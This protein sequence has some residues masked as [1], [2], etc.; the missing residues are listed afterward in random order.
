MAEQSTFENELPKKSTVEYVRGL[1]ANGN[2]ILINKSDLASV[3]GGLM[4][5]SIVNKTYTNT[6]S[7][8]TVT[9]K[10]SGLTVGILMANTSNNTKPVVLFY[11]AK[12]AG[13]TYNNSI[14]NTENPDVKIGYKSGENYIYVECTGGGVAARTFNIIIHE[15]YDVSKDID[16]QQ[17]FNKID[18]LSYI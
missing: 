9:F 4:A 6:Q 11:S 3:V 13:I 10:I 14:S 16:I 15:T 2:P 1:D 5:H 18:G 17:F 8:Q 7:A 12:G